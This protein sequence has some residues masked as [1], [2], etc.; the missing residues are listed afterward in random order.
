MLGVLCM[1]GSAQYARWYAMSQK[2]ELT[3]DKGNRGIKR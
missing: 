2:E 1:L 3:M